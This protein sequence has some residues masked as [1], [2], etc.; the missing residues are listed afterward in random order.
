ML[1]CDNKDFGSLS[2]DNLKFT[3]L[4]NKAT[5]EYVAAASAVVELHWTEDGQL[6]PS[7]AGGG[8]KVDFQRMSPSLAQ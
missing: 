8:E 3:I 4:L 7:V 1:D 5:N 6:R 2:E